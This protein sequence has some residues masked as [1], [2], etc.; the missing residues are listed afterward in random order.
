M[1]LYWKTIDDEDSDSSSDSESDNP[2]A[3]EYVSSFIGT[4]S[5]VT[6]KH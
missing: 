2:V 3:G 4:I 5:I 6:R 1:I